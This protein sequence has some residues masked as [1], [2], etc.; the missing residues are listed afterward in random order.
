M[1]EGENIYL[2]EAQ[3]AAPIAAFFNMFIGSSAVKAQI[4]PPIHAQ[5]TFTS[6]N[7]CRAWSCA[8]LRRSSK[9]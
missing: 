3:T 4:V 8:F 9:S 2:P 1:L 6:E 7:T 5:A